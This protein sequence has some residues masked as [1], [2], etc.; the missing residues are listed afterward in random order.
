MSV[1]TFRELARAAPGRLADLEPKARGL[2]ELARWGLPVPDGLLVWPDG[3]V[4]E[5][6]RRAVD[7]FRSQIPAPLGTLH[8]GRPVAA[9]VRFACK[10]HRPDLPPSFLALGATAPHDQD[11]DLRLARLEADLPGALKLRELPPEAG[12][13]S[14]VTLAL[15]WC[16]RR[17]EAS[18]VVVQRMVFG[19][20]AGSAAGMAYTRPPEVGLPAPY[21]RF[22]L[23]A[24]GWRYAESGPEDKRDLGEL[25]E[26]LPEAAAALLELLDALHTA[27][28]QTRYVEFV[29]DR[30]R[31][32]LVQNTRGRLP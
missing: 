3:D 16:R 22:R 2:V 32:F 20:G 29:V 27:A 17:G 14:A 1:A 31:V 12:V 13:R 4:V 21:G 24:E 25:A 5:V 26:A 28:G 10:R 15:A 8:E 23:D 30:G 6:A 7:V 11:R 9:T 19:R 18:P